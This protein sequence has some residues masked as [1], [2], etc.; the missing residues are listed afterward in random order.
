MLTT[1]AEVSQNWD[2]KQFHGH[3]EKAAVLWG[4]NPGADMPFNYTLE[5]LYKT[6]VG[7]H[8]HHIIFEPLISCGAAPDR[9]TQVPV[10]VG[11]LLG[12][13]LFTLSCGPATVC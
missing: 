4:T 11:S 10:F 13:P 12:L 6:Q 9:T 1:I 2:N 3:T 7:S 8:F 5:S